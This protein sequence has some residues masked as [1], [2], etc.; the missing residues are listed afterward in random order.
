[1]R[2]DA[3]KYD[4][5]NIYDS[6]KEYYPLGLD[7]EDNEMYFSYPGIAQL[8]ALMQKYLYDQDFFENTWSSFDSIVQSALGKPVI[9]TTY[10]RAPSFSSHAILEKVTAGDHTRTKELHFLVSII[11]KFYM[12]IGNDSNWIKR[13]VENYLST[14]YLVCSPEEEWESPFLKLCELIEKHFT[15]YRFVPF[16]VASQSIKGLS[17]PYTD[18]LRDKIYHALFNDQLD[19]EASKI[20][21]DPFFR[22]ELWIKTGYVASNGGWTAYPP[23]FF[24]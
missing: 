8:N 13:G 6:I 23:K 3:E 4:F 12:V 9:G 20:I 2:F 18:Q 21:G 17:V 14:S 16:S 24:Q 5:W 15:G 19:I 10:G 1:M 11:G 22:S 7:R